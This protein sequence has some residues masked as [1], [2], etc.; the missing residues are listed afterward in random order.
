V[1]AVA[2]R[3]RWRL[4]IGS[5]L[6]AALGALLL[7]GVLHDRERTRIVALPI[8]GTL[9]IVDF[10]VGKRARDLEGPLVRGSAGPGGKC[11]VLEYGGKRG[12]AWVRKLRAVTKCSL[13][14]AQSAKRTSAE[15]EACVELSDAEAEALIG[16]LQRAQIAARVAP[17]G[18]LLQNLATGAAAAPHSPNA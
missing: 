18:S 9:F 13:A 5:A 10:W 2:G 6:N 14:Q 1:R 7:Y 4:W 12:V 16:R 3:R 8:V 17:P 15:W 11:I